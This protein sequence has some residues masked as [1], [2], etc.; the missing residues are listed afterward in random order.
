MSKILII[1]DDPSN[2]E[3][4]RARLE[5]AGHE[6]LEASNGEEG[7]HMAEEIM[8]DLV[9][10]DVMMP[11]VDGLQVCRQIKATPKTAKIPVIMLTAA[12]Q[13]IDKLR[14]WESGADEFMAKPWDAVKLLELVDKWCHVA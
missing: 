6:V 3:I 2:R 11:K 10:L 9:F 14:G 1:D 5:K 13:Q 12:D 4:L 8:P 7:I